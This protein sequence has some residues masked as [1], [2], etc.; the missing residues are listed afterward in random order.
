[1]PTPGVPGPRARA[2]GRLPRRGGRLA[3]VLAV[4]AL[5][6]AACSSGSGGPAPATSPP[7][8]APSAA[9]G[10]GLAFVPCE[11]GFS[12][13]TLTVPLAGGGTTDL[14]VTRRPAT[15]ERVG[16]LVVN[17]GGPGAGAVDFLE[18]AADGL[19]PALRAGFD[20]VAVDPRG[21]GR[22]T[23]VRCGGTADLD[24]Y[25]AL[26]PTPDSPAE[27]AAYEQ[28]TAALVQG[29][30]DLSG[31]LLPHV[32]TRDA[33][34]DL[35]R[36]REALG[37][38]RLSYLGY[39]YGTAIGAAYAEAFPS[40]VRTMVLDGALDPALTWDALVEGQSR[41]FDAALAA[42]LA[43]C[44]RTRC[45]FR[46]AVTGP[47]GAAYDALEARVDASPLPTTG[48]R[49]LGP[50]E[51]TLG[52]GAGL[53]DRD[54]GWRAVADGLASAQR[55]DGR[56]LLALSDA[57]L[58][59]GDRGYASTG[60]A[61]LAVTCIDRPFP[62]TAQPYRD[63][64]ARLRQ[65]APRFGPA[66]ALATLPCATWP[67][68]AVS[69]PAPVKAEGAPPVV[70]IGTT[71]D[72]ATPYAW[73]VALAGQLASGVLVTHEGEGHTVYRDG[74]PACLQGPVDRYLLTGEA[75]AP[76]TC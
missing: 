68:P 48:D 11:R 21:V 38:E 24:R 70:V 35:D 74:A 33:A 2:A 7:G 63:L 4:V 6:L 46:R 43:E 16:V 37:E 71:G 64:A 25:W 3:A 65:S 30:A 32:S 49:R 66:I 56:A 20:L 58:Q 67:A 1:V 13:A 73:S 40:R 50:G 36:L 27:T 18:E 19:P 12:C 69:T 42:M 17:P 28:G 76:L 22:S 62:R 31:A 61:N 23:P 75:P 52:V 8:P 34:A 9:P 55:G 72:P 53:Y 39:S 44:E 14:A 59:R 10:G 54:A 29:C 57:Y 60:E 47:L 5:G 26:D 51:F 15:G 41:G 45:S